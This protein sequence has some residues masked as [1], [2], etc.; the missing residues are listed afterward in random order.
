MGFAHVSPSGGVFFQWL[1]YH[2]SQP[3]LLI[4]RFV[5]SQGVPETCVRDYQESG[6]ASKASKDKTAA[7]RLD[8]I[9]HRGTAETNA[10]LSVLLI[11]AT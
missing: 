4:R 9:D 11:N 3:G 7:L 2:G 5:R 6:P 10:L 1:I 8:H